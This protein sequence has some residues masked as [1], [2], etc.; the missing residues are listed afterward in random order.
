MDIMP[1]VGIL[2]A[3]VGGSIGLLGQRMNLKEQRRKE[4][5]ERV[6]DLLRDADRLYEL[7]HHIPPMHRV[8]DRQSKLT[9]IKEAAENLGHSDQHV[10]LV[11]PWRLRQ[12]TARM[13]RA[14]LTVL[15]IQTAASDETRDDAQDYES[16]RA[17]AIEAF[18]KARTDVVLYLRP[19]LHDRPL[20]TRKPF[21]AGMRLL[22]R[23]TPN[24][25]G[26]STH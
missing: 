2:G 18:D 4:L 10:E 20:W 17:V 1:W 8:V 6:V 19:G 14:V 15:E 11:A 16:Q 12:L 21:V 25:S 5:R 13:E 23:L 3:I 22:L 24:R 9:K 26:R 7:L